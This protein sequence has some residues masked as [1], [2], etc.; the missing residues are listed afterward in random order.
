[1]QYEIGRHWRRCG[2]EY[3]AQHCL[4]MHKRAGMDLSLW[5]EEK[6]ESARRK[7]RVACGKD[8]WHLSAGMKVVF[9]KRLNESPPTTIFVLSKIKRQNPQNFFRSSLNGN[10]G[11]ISVG[12]NY[13][14]H[15]SH[16]EGWGT[17][18]N[19]GWWKGG[20]PGGLHCHSHD[21]GGK[22]GRSG[23]D[24][25][26]QAMYHKL[27]PMHYQSFMTCLLKLYSKVF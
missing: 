12:F 8:K 3:I 22:L 14:V 7:K 9:S 2:M 23:S 18:S 20:E 26:G 15:Q 25:Y 17:V 4:I 19:P 16:W 27:K 11:K 1:M 5:G 21:H 10:W 6:E 24:L 13:S